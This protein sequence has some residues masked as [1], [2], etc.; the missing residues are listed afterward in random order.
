MLEDPALERAEIRR[1]LEPEL[2]ERRARVAV[3][4]ERVCLA[5]GAVQGEDQLAAEPLTM[6][7][8]G[9]E[10]LELADEGGVPARP[11]DPGRSVASRA[12]SRAS[13]SRAA[14]APR[15]G[16]VREVRERRP[17]PE[18]ERL[19]GAPPDRL[20]RGARSA[21]RRARRPRRGRGSRARCVTIRSAP[22][23]PRRAWTCTWRAFWA[24]AG[25]DSPQIPSMRR[26]V[27][28]AA[29]GSRRS[30]ARSARGRGPPSGTGTPSSPST[31]S[32]P[33]SRNSTP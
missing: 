27:E 22:N 12:A 6:R 29:F 5:A 15:E 4:V 28:T 33:N 11:R 3:G 21:R 14:A 25:G 7:V 9:D 30:R 2:V 18:R 8:C 1:R 32:G 23:A 16:L 26:S 24:L 10:R 31:S 20:A 19:V 13:S 17:A